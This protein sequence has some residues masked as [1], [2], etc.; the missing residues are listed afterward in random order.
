MFAISG[1]ARRGSTRRFKS[2]DAWVASALERIWK[3]DGARLSP[4]DVVSDFPR[5]RRNAEIRFRRAIGHS[6][7]DELTNARV[8]AAKRLLS[9]TSLPI[10]SVAEQCGYVSIAHFRDAFRNATGSNPLAWRKQNL[11]NAYGLLR[12]PQSK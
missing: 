4:R 7:L 10:S 11:K 5:S 9:K 12:F 3:P 8:D 2:K 6:I 1:I